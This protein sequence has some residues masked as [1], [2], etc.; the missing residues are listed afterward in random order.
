MTMINVSRLWTGLVLLLGLV[1]VPPVAGP[2]NA[3]GKVEDKRNH[4][5]FKAPERPPVPQ[6]K[7]QKWVRNAI[8][9]FILARLEKEGL[10]PSPEA[11]RVILIRRLSLDLTGLPPTVEA[12]DQFLADSS[13]DAYRKLVERL[14][15][16]FHF[17]E[18]LRLP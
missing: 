5:A 8:D 9:N 11:D 16:S 12:V 10:S 1:A 6:V 7:N 4:W 13:P 14:L 17:R 3:A 15:S 18:V 2:D